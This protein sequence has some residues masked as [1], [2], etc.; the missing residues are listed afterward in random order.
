MT[1]HLK[2]DWNAFDNMSEEELEKNA[3][4]DPDAQPMDE[5]FL[6]N[7]RVVYP[8]GNKNFSP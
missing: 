2:T 3:W 7:A 4:D 8:V 6:K 5:A 1:K